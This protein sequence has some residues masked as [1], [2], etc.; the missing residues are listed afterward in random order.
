MWH[1]RSCVPVA[2]DRN[3]GFVRG[4]AP[5]RVDCATGTLGDLLTASA[6]GLARR[7]VPD[8]RRHLLVGAI[9]GVWHIPYMRAT[10]GYTGLPPVTFAVQLTGSILAMALV[11][12]QMREKS[13]TVWPTV[14]GRSDSVIMTEAPDT[15]AGRQTPTS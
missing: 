4:R 2:E 9:W 12:G 5:H 1:T 6:A 10:P 14:L 13:R 8:L 11:Y 15:P 7:G 3:P